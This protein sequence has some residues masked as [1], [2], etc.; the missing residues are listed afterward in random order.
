MTATTDLE[1]GK[2]CEKL[3]EELGASGPSPEELCGAGKTLPPRTPPSAGAQPVP[4]KL[5]GT[6]L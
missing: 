2:P 6:S 5:Q 3:T 1:G 4:P